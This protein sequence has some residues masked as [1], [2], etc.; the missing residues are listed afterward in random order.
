M[1]RIAG[2]SAGAWCAAFYCCDLTT[3]AWVDT[4]IRTK[5]LLDQGKSLMEAHVEAI[6]HQVSVVV[7]QK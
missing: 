4:F 3:D 5:Q 1:N 7:R 6:F 2:T